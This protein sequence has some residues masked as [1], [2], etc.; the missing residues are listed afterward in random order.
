ME[1][2]EEEW[3]GGRRSSSGGRRSS[4]GGRRSGVEEEEQ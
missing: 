1:W 2:R 4:S 3:S